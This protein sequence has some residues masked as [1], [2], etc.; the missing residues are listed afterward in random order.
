M[1]AAEPRLESTRWEVLKRWAIPDPGLSLEQQFF[2]GLCLL[3]GL[4]TILVVIP[5]N[6]FLSLSPWVGW[7]LFAF[8]LEA[9][10]MAWA[11][12]RGRYFKKT[13]LVSFVIL[14]DLLWFPNGGSFG[15][16]G[17]YFFISTL[18][19]VIFFDGIT[20]STG[21]A[22]VIANTVGLLVAELL[23]PQLAHPFQSPMDRMMDLTTGYLVSLLT[24][25]LILWVILAGFNRRTRQLKDTLQALQESEERY[26]LLFENMF[27][28]F[29]LLEVLFD[30][31]GHPVDHRLLQANSECER[32]T[33]LDRSKEIGKTSEQLSFKWPPEVA[34]SYYAVALGGE[35]LHFERYNES[36]QRYY[37]V[38]ISSHQHGQFALLFNDITDRKRD[39]K[40]LA[41]REAELRA[42]FESSQDAIGVST[43]GIHEMVNPAYLAM[44][45]YQRADELTGTPLLDLIAP[46]CREQVQTYIQARAKGEPAPREYVVTAQRLDGS[47]FPME[48]HIS[49]YER[50]GSRHSVTTLRDISER[51]RL[52]EERQQ[53][54]VQARRNDKMDSLG[55][56]A[57]GM[58]HDMNNVLGAIMALA[59]VHLEKAMVGSPLF[60][61]MDTIAKAC[62]RGGILV[63]GLLGF[64]REGLA[65]ERELDL[66][67]VVRD[68][69]ALLERTTLQRVRLVT[70]LA[71]DLHPVLGDPSALCHALMNLCVNAV[72]AMPGGGTL[73]L[74]TWNEDDGSVVLEVADTGSG[75]PQEVLD[76]AL[77][78]FFTTKP[79]GKGTGLG[80]PIVYGTVKAHRGRMEIQ[81][82]SGK[83]TR[84]CLR[85]PACAPL[86][87]APKVS[88][89]PTIAPPSRVL[90]VLL[91]DDDE[92]IQSAVQGILEALGHTAIIVSGGEQAL[93][94]FEA[95]LQPD[96]VILDMN[97]P[98]LDGAATLPRLRALRPGL[99]VLLATGRVDQTATNLLE[100]HPGVL[101]LS[102]PFGFDDLQQKLEYLGAKVRAGS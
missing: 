35:P 58:A 73:T 98:G 78:P 53:L 69:V 22:L 85:L 87:Q 56:L 24:S 75:M 7:S 32:M 39:E 27:T 5:V 12:R 61:D 68:E 41:E 2:Q 62:Q 77:D 23:W 70:D 42:L 26:R 16:I 13:V 18:Y 59:T 25:A 80:L 14:L 52:E 91:V 74:R 54:E 8:G 66:N 6:C 83:G 20:R 30:A 79:Q 99:P 44:F 40:N 63:K 90:T 48:V 47:T 19:M 101:L 92:L 100:A 57:G 65:E 67:V 93:A 34:Q 64:A 55:S 50:D 94:L 17:L 37:E 38:R 71:P 81:S 95:G 49:T 89:R 29:I 72:D 1:K 36:L 9:L 46:E 88:A 51:L 96:V 10:V 4:V 97:M 21:I 102:K 86:L 45:G 3:G 28:G 76:K 33:R 15:S 60:K 31:D 43:Q 11:A 82:Q 84:V